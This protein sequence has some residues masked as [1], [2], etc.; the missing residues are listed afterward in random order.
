MKV[1]KLFLI[2]AVLVLGTLAITAQAKMV[3]L[4]DGTDFPNTLISDTANGAIFSQMNAGAQGTG[5]IDPFLRIQAASTESGFN[6]GSE[7]T[8]NGLKPLDDKDQGGTQYNHVL[9]L[10]TIPV[11]HDP[12]GFSGDYRE[13]TLDLNES[14][15]VLT[16]YLSMDL[17]KIYNTSD[18]GI[19]TLAGLNALTA[20]DPPN[21][22]Y[23]LDSGP[24]GD[25]W[26]AINY[27][28]NGGSGNGDIL[29]YIPSNLFTDPYVYVYSSFG[30]ETVNT[31]HPW[32]TNDGFEEWAVRIGTTPPPPIPAPG[33]ILL[34][35]IGVCLVG[36]L[37]KR[38]TI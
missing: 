11:V 12:V 38:R 28:L 25:S 37:R 23:D 32:E 21:P 30:A 24:D 9:L 27:G 33:A 34:G 13:L 36:W 20:L 1:F 29:V 5:N 7:G 18:G 16:Q 2:T 22:I 26:V 10:D 31:T 15:S 14:G 19:T 8:P 35:G 17:L 4:T 3:D 6:L